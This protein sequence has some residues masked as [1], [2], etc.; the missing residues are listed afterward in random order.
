MKRGMIG[1]GRRWGSLAA[2]A[3][4]LALA[5][6]GTVE[7]RTALQPGQWGGDQAL[8]VVTTDTVALGL[9]CASGWVEP[10]LLLDGAGRFDVAG[11]VQGQIGAA[12][13]PVPARFVGVVSPDTATITLQLTISPPQ[14]PSATL[15]P[16]HLVRDQLVTLA[17]CR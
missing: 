7:P 8:L 12:R 13:P 2:A 15:G 17:L 5:C 4:C 9:D 6:S 14:Q 10:P 1:L 3:A 16:Y 11:F